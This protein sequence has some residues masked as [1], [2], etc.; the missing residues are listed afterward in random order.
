MTKSQT[1]PK[2]THSTHSNASNSAANY[3]RYRAIIRRV[4]TFDE[5]PDLVNLI[6]IRGFS[7]GKPTPNTPDEYND[8]I[9]A[10]WLDRDGSKRTREFLATVDPGQ[11]FTQDPMRRAGCAHLC[12]G[13][14]TYKRGK[15]KGRD[16]LVQASPVTIWRDADKN[17]RRGPGE[18]TETGMFGINIHDAGSGSQVGEWSAG[19][20]GIHKGSNGKDWAEFLELLD[21][22]DSNKIRYTLVDCAALGYEPSDI[23]SWSELGTPES[24]RL[25]ILRVGSSG[26]E[27]RDLQVALAEADC[28]P[29]S[30]D[31]IFGRKTERAVIQYQRSSGLRADGIV[32]PA[33]WASICSQTKQ[34]QTAPASAGLK[35]AL[36]VAIDDYGDPRNNLPSCVA[37]ARAFADQLQ[38]YGFHSSN[39]KQL[40]NGEATLGALEQGLDWLF[41]GLQPED[42]AV[43]FY[44]GHG[45]QMPVDDVLTEVLVLRDGFYLDDRL[46]ERSQDLPDGVLTAV[47]DSCFS[48]GM[49]KIVISSVGGSADFAAPKRWTKAPQEAP[50]QKNGPGLTGYRRF[51]ASKQIDGEEGDTPLKGL[52]LSA[53]SENET[54][55]ASTSRTRGL[56]AFTYSLLDAI[57]E[58]GLQ[59]S[60]S[61]LMEQVRETLSNHGF[62]QRPTLHEPPGPFTLAERDFLSTGVETST[63]PS[64]WAHIHDLLNLWNKETTMQSTSDFAQ[65]FEPDLTDDDQQKA[66]ALLGMLAPVV[67]NTLIKRRRK[68]KAFGDFDDFDDSTE[69]AYEPFLD[70]MDLTNILDDEEFD[71]GEDKNFMA[72]AES[73]LPT[74]QTAISGLL[75]SG[76]EGSNQGVR[77]RQNR[78]NG[79]H[80]GRGGKRKPRRKEFEASDAE[81]KIFR[82]FFKI[83]TPL[84]SGKVRLRAK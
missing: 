78:R 72:L 6:G 23:D 42:R 70:E 52:M 65:G 51:G 82:L 59:A 50:S 39:V 41:D 71:E 38:E 63:P 36:L 15:H 53:C 3:D 4:G 18:R 75:G 11:H 83:A 17:H 64:P 35:R 74:V 29:G 45:H 13:Q 69:P 37:D 47:L 80:R 25:P 31:G 56:S 1:I 61:E 79:S 49:D 14:Y 16:A 55:S 48:G 24:A 34:L 76:N 12:D 32:G 81:D 8:T 57:S 68:K 27:V 30:I 10:V 44:S 26:S 66:F 19:C 67:I 84:L 62:R 9:V 40:T 73:L 5:G 46:A 7:K 58:Q 60:A 21:L 54:A 2:R 77:Q 43:F 33:T 20:Q 28:S 22:H